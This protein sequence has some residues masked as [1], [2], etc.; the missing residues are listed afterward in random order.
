MPESCGAETEAN[1]LYTAL[2]GSDDIA[3]PAF[4][5][6]GPQYMV[7]STTGNVL[8]EPITNLTNDNL[9]TRTVGGSGTFDAL[10]ASVKAHLTEEYE[11]NRIT[12]AEYTKAYIALVAQAMDTAAQFLL[13]RE[14]SH[15][16][17]LN[18]QMAARLAEVQVVTSRVQLDAAKAQAVNVRFDALTAKANFTGAKIRL[19]TEGINYCLSEFQLNQTLPKQAIILDKQAIQ[20]DKQAAQLDKQTL[21]VTEQME[22]QRAQTLDT[23][24]DGTPVVGSIGKQKALHTQ[25]ITSYQRDAEVKAGK[26]F[27]DAF[28][29][30]KTIDEGLLP[31]NGFTNLS[32]DQVLTALKTN[33]GLG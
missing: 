26:L 32:L 31:P 19:A 9:T 24:T 14:Q 21:L 1:G 33:N 2:L 15:W 16:N 30:M 3:V 10:M 23:R 4:D 22:A 11:K 25:Q 7:P 18:A 28:I 20:L 12:G 27:T 17:A 6:A 13:G 29:T 5:L 8:Y